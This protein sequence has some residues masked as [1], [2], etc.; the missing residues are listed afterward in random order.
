MVQLDSP[1]Q[2]DLFNTVYINQDGNDPHH[3]GDGYMYRGRGYIQIT[4]KNK[5]KDFTTEHNNHNPNEPRNFLTN[6]DLVS[7]NIAYAV[8]S[9]FWYWRKRGTHFTDINTVADQGASDN[10]VLK[11]GANVNGWFPINQ[12][13]YDS[14]TSTK[15]AQYLRIEENRWLK[16]PIG[17]DDR[18]RKFH[19]IKTL[20]NLH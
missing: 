13:K 19:A 8:E 9:A 2:P 4:G 16:I 6:P 12:D 15:K 17:H 11:V 14:L 7:S 18:L 1:K 3:V 5:Y 20:L 10:D